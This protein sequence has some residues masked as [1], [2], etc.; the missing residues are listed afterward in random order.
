MNGIRD[1][2]LYLIGTAIDLYLFILVIRMLLAYVGAN[3]SDPLIQFVV[4]ATDPLIRPIRRVIPNVRGIELSTV[5]C[6]L[7][8]ETIKYTM[9]TLITDGNFV[10]AGIVIISIADAIKIFLQ[11]FFY[12]IILQVVLAWVQPQ[13][14]VIGI[15][16]RLTAP[17]MRPVQRLCP[18]IGGFDISPIPAIMLI[19]LT[20]IL[21]VN[22]LW[23]YGMGVLL[24]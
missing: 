5:L 22:P 24:G 15:L 11:T 20:I 16:Y 9:I 19:Q 21:V 12:A 14:P 2:L 7:A 17:I 23:T 6:V 18:T 3:Y 8:L 4:R 10:F 1:A 13:S